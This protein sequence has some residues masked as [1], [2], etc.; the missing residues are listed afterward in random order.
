M[1]QFNGVSFFPNRGS[2][3]FAMTMT[4]AWVENSLLSRSYI[5]IVFNR[6]QLFCLSLMLFH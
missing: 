3:S 4:A 6:L 1:C 2:F 5:P